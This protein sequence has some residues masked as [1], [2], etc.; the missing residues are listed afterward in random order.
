MY[1][2]FSHNRTWIN[3]DQ[4]TTSDA[5]GKY[6]FK[7]HSQLHTDNKNPSLEIYTKISFRGTIEMGGGLYRRLRP[8]TKVTV[9]VTCPSSASSWRSDHSLLLM[10]GTG[11]ASF[12]TWLYSP[13][14]LE[15]FPPDCS[16]QSFLLFWVYHSSLLAPTPHEDT[17]RKW[18]RAL[19]SRG[20]TEATVTCAIGIKDSQNYTFCYKVYNLLKT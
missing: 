11:E 13:S 8:T 19:S 2:L 18:N 20:I 17:G 1:L 15:S 5:R 14:W 3:L 12:P 9:Q 4:I 10:I 6:C 16:F 7:F